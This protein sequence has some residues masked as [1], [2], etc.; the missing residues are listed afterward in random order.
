MA[1]TEVKSINGK[2]LYDKTAREEIGKL[3]EDIAD[4]KKNGTGTGSGLTVEMATA[5]DNMFKVCAYTKEDVSEECNA[6]RNAFG[7]DVVLIPATAITLT[8][9][10]LSFT[11][12]NDSRTLKATL[13]PTDSTDKVTWTSSNEAVAKVV[14]GVVTVVG[15]G[16][17][18]IT[19]TATSG[20]SATCT[21]NVEFASTVYTVTNTLENVTNSNSATTVE[22]GSNYIAYLTVAEGYE[23]T[24][25]KITMGGVDIT[26]T[27]YANGTISI[28]SVTGN[29]V[30]EAIATEINT[31]IYELAEPLVCDGTN[32]VDTGVVVCGTGNLYSKDSTI[33][34]EIWIDASTMQSEFEKFPPDNAMLFAISDYKKFGSNVYTNA[35]VRSWIC[36][37][38]SNVDINCNTETYSVFGEDTIKLVITRSA[39]QNGFRL[40]GVS[41]KKGVL[42]DDTINGAYGNLANED[43]STLVLGAYYVD[44]TA[45]PSTFRGKIK[46]FAIYNEIWTDETI[47]EFLGVE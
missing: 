33:S 28:N 26:A 7:L 39:G 45:T 14:N 4:L 2:T 6:F 29:I 40:R 19:A 38:G 24:A 10:T 35:I 17:A 15:E 34:A 36:A 27:A 42:K 41:S 13:E 12:L 9:S 46:Q 23:L 21:V 44:G 20:V 11:S 25:P 8:S 3:S 18:T 22:E 43:D 5:L 31:L 16:T 47:N 30:I 32:Y 37:S 1:E